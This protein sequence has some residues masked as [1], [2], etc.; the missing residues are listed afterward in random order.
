[1]SLSRLD[2]AV[3]E[4]AA[5]SARA[6]GLSPDEGEVAGDDTNGSTASAGPEPTL[7][8]R[9]GGTVLSN[10]PFSLS[11]L[12]ALHWVAERRG[13]YKVRGCMRG[14]WRVRFPMHCIALWLSMTYDISIACLPGGGVVGPGPQLPPRSAA[15]AAAVAGGA[16]VVAHHA[17]VEAQRG[18]GG[19][20]PL[21]ASINMGVGW[22]WCC[23]VLSQASVVARWGWEW[24]CN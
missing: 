19:A 14:C 2:G 16:A 6:L 13:V 1:M 17:A 24:E 4:I 12:E 22:G 18:G 5:E 20:V 10:Y 8:L 3:A 9:S 21:Q 23:A 7:R 15:E 11:Q